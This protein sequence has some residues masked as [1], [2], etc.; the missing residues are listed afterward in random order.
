M[1]SF[2]K[3][4]NLLLYGGRGCSLPPGALW[5][6]GFEIEAGPDFAEAL[7]EF[8]ARFSSVPRNKLFRCRLCVHEAVLNALKYGRGNVFLNAWGNDECTEVS[9]SQAAQIIWPEK[10][11]SFRGTALIKRY[12]GDIRFS[13]DKRTIYLL[14]Y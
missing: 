13:L 4:G 9:V 14:F 2:V 11:E 1:R 8:A 5:G 10:T 7:T 6:A 12:A 3:K